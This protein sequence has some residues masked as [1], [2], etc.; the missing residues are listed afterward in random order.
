[1]RALIALA[2]TMTALL[3]RAV[4]QEAL[5]PEAH[6]AHEAIE[7]VTIS[8]E[9]AGPGLWKIRKG[10][11]TL[12][13]FGTI[14]PLPKKMVWRSRDVER[15]LESSQ[16][17][18]SNA[19]ASVGFNPITWARIMWNAPKMFKDPQ[20]AT[21]G[22]SLPP[23][24]F[25]R[26]ETLRRKYAPEKTDLLTQRPMFAGT[27]LLSAAISASGLT[28]A[29]DVRRTVAKLAKVRG[30]KVIE[31][32]IK[33][34]DPLGVMREI[35]QFPPEAEVSC[36]RVM[37]DRLE[38]DLGVMRAQAD[39]W[40]SGDV[41]ALRKQRLLDQPAEEACLAIVNGPKLA[42]LVRQFESTWFDA[43]VM[44]LEQN[45]SS[46]AVASI[47]QFFGPKGLLAKFVARGY[48]VVDP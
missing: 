22:K 28:G 14:S 45:K 42:E 36:V 6:A 34:D 37:V 44:A 12:Y 48:E 25:E 38:G 26:F 23:E 2:F 10:D 15:A 47:S 40:A 9:R 32:K 43:A 39:A 18:V 4:A 21:L 7:E 20:N 17:F 46:V 1:M 3:P 35:M 33:L 11:H 30:L 13:L 5:P 19:R 16:V 27:G 29:V 24:L 8:G 41:D 31:P